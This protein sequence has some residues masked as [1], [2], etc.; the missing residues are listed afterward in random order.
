MDCN[1]Y[2]VDFTVLKEITNKSKNHKNTP[3]KNIVFPFEPL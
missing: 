3:K 2:I 1:S